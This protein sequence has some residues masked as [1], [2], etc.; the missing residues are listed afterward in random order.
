MSAQ[1]QEGP[2][3]FPPTRWTLVRRVQEGDES[4]ASRAME[5]LCGQYWYPIYAFTRRYGYAPHD[6][7]DLTQSFFQRLIASRTIH[8]ARQEQGR[9][10]SFMLGLLKRVLA[11]HLRRVHA[12]KRGWSPAATV[13]FD[14]AAPEERY[15]GEPIE[16]RD[17]EAMFDRAW[18]EGVLAT[19]ERKLRDEFA[20]ADNLDSYEQ[21]REFLPLGDNATPYVEAA[22][23]LRIAEGTLRLQIHRMRKRYGKLI[24]EEIAQTVDGPGEVKA[25][26]DHLMTVIG[27]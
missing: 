23:K 12:G 14:D 8:D 10:R 19:A 21:L 4:A 13:S 15:A 3:P 2:A 7:E 16:I 6:A 27:R 24:E 11:D 26:L 1:K 25:E 20:K 5:E 9:L 18:A 17:P 22:K